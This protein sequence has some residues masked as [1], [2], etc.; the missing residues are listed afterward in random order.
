MQYSKHFIRL[1]NNRILQH[2][3]FWGFFLFLE[4]LHIYDKTSEVSMLSVLLSVISKFSSAIILIYLNLLI[5]I[6]Y[7]LEK[8]KTLFYI[9]TI[10]SS[11]FIV[12]YSVYG[13]HLLF[14]LERFT[15]IEDHIERPKLLAMLFGLTFLL[16]TLSSL[17]HFAKRWIKLKDVELDFKEEQRQRLEAELK[18]LKAQIN[19]HFLFNSLN[20]IYSLSLDKSDL[21]PE[22]ILKLSDLMSY[23]IYD[24]REE[25]VPLKKELGFIENHID[26]ER[27]RINNRVN[28]KFENDE[29]LLRY[30]IAP[31]LFTPF[32]ENAFK[33]VSTPEN[34]KAF[35]NIKLSENQYELHFFIENSAEEELATFEHNNHG[36]GIE[37]V[38]KRLELI[39]PNKH[40]LDIEHSS[41]KFSINLKIKI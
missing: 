40:K 7:L 34:Q 9:I 19:P 39:Y 14:S 12:V 15:F 41:T 1:I 32:I 20:N 16:T 26:L 28:V 25:F 21:A 33:Y 31:L 29:S 5:F 24:A 8:N 37:N 2:L 13:F 18:T 23:I 36:I 35:I 38:K 17:V 30:N 27:I 6:P 22:M 11:Y 3:L 10:V 4:T